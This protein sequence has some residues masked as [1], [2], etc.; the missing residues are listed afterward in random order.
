LSF[1]KE[2]IEDEM[3]FLSKRDRRNLNEFQN[4]FSKKLVSMFTK[5]RPLKNRKPFIGT[6]RFI[7]K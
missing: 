3:K 5:K 2:K 7:N 1:S 4:D 6:K